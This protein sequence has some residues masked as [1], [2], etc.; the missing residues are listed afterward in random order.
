MTGPSVS[1]PVTGPFVRLGA[2]DRASMFPRLGLFG[3]AVLAQRQ[4]ARRYCRRDQ[5]HHS[6]RRTGGV[7]GEAGV[8]DPLGSGRLGPGR[9]VE[10][11]YL[12]RAGFDRVLPRQCR[13]RA[14]GHW[15][16]DRRNDKYRSWSGKI[17]A[18][19]LLRQR[20]G[21][22]PSRTA[23][24]IR[25]CSVN[26]EATSACRISTRRS[27]F[28][29]SPSRLEPRSWPRHCWP[30]KSGASRRQTGTDTARPRAAFNRRR[31]W[32]PQTCRRI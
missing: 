22:G 2:R 6:A 13:L 15:R 8:C 1:I 14:A 11:D 18:G 26:R 4:P 27:A 20:Q 12:S 16:G 9:H 19:F 5:Q 28:S 21:R 7:P 3:R 10:H 32:Q 23:P 30:W 17:R 25:S 24:A 29:Q 31:H